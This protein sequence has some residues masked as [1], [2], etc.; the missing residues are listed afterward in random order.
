MWY[1]I[2]ISTISGAVIGYGTNYLAI[3][4]LFHPYHRIGPFYGVIPSRL[5]KFAES[6]GMLARN[7]GTSLAAHSNDLSRLR[8][9]A[10][11]YTLGKLNWFQKML[12]GVAFMFSRGN[13]EN[14]LPDL[15]DNLGDTLRDITVERI[16]DMELVELEVNTYRLVGRELFM[17]EVYGALLGGLLGFLTAL[18]MGVIK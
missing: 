9:V 17:L 18:L 14:N 16:E 4:M 15:V 5:D 11:Q 7:Y 3:K 6:L 12:Y 1:K 13:L 2:L 8:N 10:Y